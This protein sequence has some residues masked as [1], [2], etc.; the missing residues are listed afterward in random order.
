MVVERGSS[1]R[2]ASKITTNVL[3]N[4]RGAR[5]D[6]ETDVELGSA[7]GIMPSKAAAE[8]EQQQQRQ[9]ASMTVIALKNELRQRGLKVSGKKA[10]L[11]ERLLR[12]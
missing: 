10:E 4:G 11:V 12:A 8:V 9:W 6:V 5:I 3:G 7:G 1:G 2:G